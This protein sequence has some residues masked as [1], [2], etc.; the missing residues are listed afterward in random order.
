MLA[1]IPSFRS[2]EAIRKRLGISTKVL[3]EAIDFLL[4]SGLLQQDGDH[5][6]S[7]TTRIHLGEDSAILHKHHANWRL[8][9]L[10]ALEREEENDL[11][12]SSA[13]TISKADAKNIREQL[14]RA[15]ESAKSVIKDSAEEELYSLCLDFFRA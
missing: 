15:I 1:T 5:F 14:T 11:H 8:R 2:R 4:A 6:L 7:G 3:S 9:A 13:I 12:Y 10:L